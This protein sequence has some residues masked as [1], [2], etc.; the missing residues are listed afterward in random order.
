MDWIELTQTRLAGTIITIII[1]QRHKELSLLT[2]GF[3]SAPT[4]VNIL[5]YPFPR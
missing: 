3:C 4:V 2:Y 5:G 1:I